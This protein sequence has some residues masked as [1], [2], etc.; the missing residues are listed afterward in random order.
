MAFWLGPAKSVG[1]HGIWHAG[2]DIESHRA[3]RTGG[4]AALLVDPYSVGKIVNGIQI[5]AYDAERRKMLI[6]KGR[7]RA[8]LH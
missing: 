1:D 4:D 7:G 6:K 2:F 8:H 3:A 5:L